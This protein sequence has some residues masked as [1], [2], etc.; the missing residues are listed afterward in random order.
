MKT[1]QA[2]HSL[3]PVLLK[4]SSKWTRTL[5]SSKW[6]TQEIS[7]LY[8]LIPVL[9]LQLKIVELIQ[10]E[11][12]LLTLTHMHRVKTSQL[13]GKDRVLM[14]SSDLEEVLVA[15]VT[16]KLQHNNRIQRLQLKMIYLMFSRQTPTKQLLKNQRNQPMM[17]STIYSQWTLP[18]LSNQRQLS[19]LSHSNRIIAW[20]YWTNSIRSSSHLSQLSSPLPKEIH[21]RP[22]K[23]Y[24]ART[25]SVPWWINKTCSSLHSN[26]NSSKCRVGSN[27]WWAKVV[28]SPWQAKWIKWTWEWEWAWEETWLWECKPTSLRGRKVWTHSIIWCLVPSS[29]NNSNFKVALART[30][31][32]LTD[33]ALQFA[34]ICI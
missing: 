7:Q 21:L 23:T 22:S 13:L 26:S 16:A 5:D 10:E 12:K 6:S 34:H 29:S 25:R 14:T 31:R 9:L 2:Q 1:L 20:T 3:S 19:K 33:Q 32:S 4:K 17:H 28:S 24:R 30:N 15:K 27:L 11:L 8:P 18:R